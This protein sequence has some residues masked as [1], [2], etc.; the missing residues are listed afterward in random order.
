MNK[1]LF[2][3]FEGID[4]S[5]KSTQA[6][7]LAEKM[8]AEGHK[9]HLT[10][11]PTD[12]NIGRM[13]RSILKGEVKA[14]ERVIAS[15]FTADRLDHLLNESNGVMKKLEDGYSVITD[16][17]YFSSYA[18]NGTHVSLDWVINAN[19][20]SAEIRRP[21][22]NLFIDVPPEVCMARLNSNREKIELYETQGNLTKVRT[23]YLEVFEMMK[24]VEKIWVVDGNRDPGLIAEEIWE[25]VKQFGNLEI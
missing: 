17:Y 9:V 8:T 11:E 12:G 15:L 6:K 21:D 1:P 25:K 23:R 2:I 5:G 13:L 3:A 16:R 22:M 7:L 14:D 4:G 10:F 24:K 19:K 20:L 18:Y